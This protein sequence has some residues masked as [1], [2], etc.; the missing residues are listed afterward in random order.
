MQVYNKAL[1]EFLQI[2]CKQIRF[3]SIHKQITK[4]LSD[5]IDDQKNEYLKQG[6]DEETASFKALEQMGDPVLVGKELDKTHKPKT[7]WS[8]LSLAVILVVIGGIIQYFMSGVNLNNSNNF[9]YFLL[10][11]PVGIG[12]FFFAYFFDYTL[13][14][15]YSKITYILMF[16]ITIA[17]FFIFNRT[18]GGYR[19]VYYSFMLFIPIFA[20]IV[21]SFRSKGYLGI[22]ASGLFYA[23]TAIII[24]FAPSFSG[25]LLL[26]AS[27]LVIL[28]IAILKGIFNV[29]KLAGLAIV[30][31]P[32]L[33]TLSF[34]ILNIALT[35][36]YKLQRFAIMLN[37]NQDLRGSGWQF[38]M[39]RRLFAA[40][41]PLGT[42]TIVGNTTNTSIFQ[43]LPGWST[44][45]SLTYII[46][47]FGYIPGMILII[48]MSILI[49]RMFI[50]VLKQRN[51]FGFL[52]SFSAFLAISGQIVL[53][54]LSNLGVIAPFAG[55]LPFISFGAFGFVVNMALLGLLLSVYRRTGLVN[56]RLQNNAT[57]RRLFTLVDGK[58]IIDLGIK[59]SEK[60][61]REK[62]S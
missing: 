56:D 18:N 28:T 30:F 45:F 25:L 35:S 8:I 61:K 2:I 33:L 23:G 4:E 37:P 29:N 51:I 43:F 53:Y 39:I 44:D 38:L 60:R 24:I 32:T 11:A 12:I 21:Y 3:K 6:F 16:S 27:C 50:S 15:R 48:V 54:V 1:Q 47:R 7:E 36:P 20:A 41:K 5:H 9:S 57:H 58:L 55:N 59:P 26:T 46:V 52:L 34:T 10:Y 22:L 40:S 19:H 42:A 49:A 14:G 13:F 17:G 62:I 31:I